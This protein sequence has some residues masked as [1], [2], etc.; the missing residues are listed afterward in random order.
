MKN[1][2]FPLKIH[3]DIKHLLNKRLTQKQ[4]TLKAFGATIETIISK[5]NIMKNSNYKFI[6]L[7]FL[8]VF[9]LSLQSC[10]VSFR[11]S[12]K[13]EK[14]GW[15]KNTNNPHHPRTTNPGHT[16]KKKKEKK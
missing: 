2:L 13:T 15:G 9:T 14:K 3:N 11:K 10:V 4:I 5:L 7:L 12:Y 6:G 8:L 1:L 16:K